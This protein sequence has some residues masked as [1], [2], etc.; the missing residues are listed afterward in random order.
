MSQDLYRKEAYESRIKGFSNPVTIRGSL[1]ATILTLGL[2]LLLAGL[3]SY[4]WMTDYRRKVTAPGFVAPASGSVAVTA[5]TTGVARIEVENGATIEKGDLLAVITDDRESDVNKSDMELEL[6]ALRSQRD[7]IDQRIELSGRRLQS[8][9]RVYDLQLKNIESGIATRQRI[10]DMQTEGQSLA[11]TARDRARKMLDSEIGTQSDLER[12]DTALL[13]A[14]QQLVDAETA[15]LDTQ[16][17]ID[18][19]RVEREIENNALREELIGYRSEKSSLNGR[20][21]RLEH[22]RNREI[23]APIDGVVTFSN[24]RNFER[25]AEREPLFTIDPAGEDYIATL[26]AP[27]SAIG[28][29]KPGDEVSIRYEAYPY[30][31]NGIFSGRVTAIDNTAQ[32]PAAFSAPIGGDQPVYRIYA[33]VDQSPASKRG[34]ELR[35]FSGMVLEASITADEKPV[36]LWLLDPVL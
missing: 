10:V 35:L 12:A 16:N 15:L 11:R 26:L 2:L 36:L 30:R 3:A 22:K 27:S 34:E 20:I 32:L 19:T 9:E 7:L 8:A 25:V 28:F 17:E 29:V 5:P 21:D 31:E 1:S 33:E 6:E 23:R 24:A 18:S 14:N 13:A 4:G